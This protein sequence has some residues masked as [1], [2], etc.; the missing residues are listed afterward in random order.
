MSSPLAETIATP[1]PESPPAL[2]PPSRGLPA[3]D[4]EWLEADGL[5]GFAS[6]TVGLVRSR[7]YHAL[8]LA[9]ARPPTE[10]FVLVG[11][12][13]VWA[14]TPRDCFALC[15]HEFSPSVMHPDG[16]SRIAGFTSDP[17][18]TWEFACDDGTRIRQEVCVVR[19]QPRVV[20]CWTLLAS[21]GGQSTDKLDKGITLEVRPLLAGRD[22]HATHHENGV[23]QL[24]PT[25]EGEAWVWRLYAG[26]PGV[27]VHASG[28][29]TH[30]PCW[31]KRF[32]YREESA[33]GFAGE[34]DLAPPGVFRLRLERD[35]PASLVLTAET[36]SADGAGTAPVPPSASTLLDRERARRATCGDALDR[37]ADQYLVRRGPGA[38]I[39]AGYPWFA[40]WGRD[41]FIAMRGLCLARGRLDEARS[42]LVG[43][44]GAVSGGMLPNRFPDR[45]ESPEYNSVDAA[46][47]YTVCV[48]E[49]L[50]ASARRGLSL[51]PGER[52]TLESAVHEIIT[53]HIAG[54]RHGIRVDD[55]GLLAAGE[56]GVQLTWMD[57]R[58]GE[59]VITPRMGK[60]VEVQA[61][62]LA[63]LWAAGRIRGHWAEQWSDV[64]ARGVRSFREKFWNLR[65]GCL[66]DVVDDSHVPGQND[67]AIRPN[68]LLAVGGLPV[69]VLGGE[70]ARSVV[71]VVERRLMT[72]MGPRSLDPASPSYAGRYE[73]GPELRDAVYHQ[74]TVWPWLLGPFVE[75]WV[76][77]RGSIRAARREA[78]DRFV[79]PLLEHLRTSGLGH[80]SEIADGDAPHTPRG[81]PFQAWSLGE[82]I[83]L[84]RFVL[85]E[86]GPASAPV[87]GLP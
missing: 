75:A 63:A 85:A 60:P 78:R 66:F 28:A 76:R 45:G 32:L 31:Y 18:P 62:W 79:A 25:R 13:D 56:P 40:D 3:L 41:T 74:G 61:L 33:R 30:E 84:E 46:L 52:A 83:R 71:D 38:S 51:G 65:T 80:I 58:V 16:A 57:A 26:V 6:G 14:R 23:A 87:P 8:L 77:V 19:G 10:R 7:R 55:D 1:A 44:A 15:Q 2:G 9:A 81:C 27:A 21:P 50:E 59:R 11:A 54:T 4:A 35:T 49:Y 67:S 86:A 17:W 5:G 53:H 29:Y 48:H 22:Y 68:Q 39:I 69:C 34:E 24:L 64:L 70:R 42:I 82:L 12:L 47:W 36:P 43:W 73:G 37:A 72:P 20:V